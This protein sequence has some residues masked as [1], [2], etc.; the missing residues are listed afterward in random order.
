MYFLPHSQFSL[1]VKIRFNKSQLIEEAYN[2]IETQETV[3]T[4]LRSFL[5]FL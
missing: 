2:F 1:L 3:T 5:F 4:K